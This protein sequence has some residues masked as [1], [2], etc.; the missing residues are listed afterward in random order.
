MQDVW[1]VPPRAAA[2]DRPEPGDFY[3]TTLRVYDPG[4]DHW[5]ILWVDPLFQ[6]YR[7]MIGRAVG[8]DIVQEG[9]DESGRPVRWSFREITDNS[10]SWRAERAQDSGPG[11]DL[12]G[13]FFARRRA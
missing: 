7:R 5:H 1:I 9:S 10:F 6:T 3:G 11:F 8:A 12:V 4:R 13:E 2:A